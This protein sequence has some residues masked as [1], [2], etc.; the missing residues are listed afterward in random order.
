VASAR[1]LEIG[2]RDLFQPV[3]PDATLLLWTGRYPLADE[4]GRWNLRARRLP[5]VVKDLCAG[6]FDLVLC[7]ASRYAPWAPYRLL[8]SLAES[9]VVGFPNAVLCDL[10]QYLPL[11]AGDTPLAIVD[12]DD[13]PSIG[14]HMLP[15]MRRC[16]LYFKR[17]LPA[18]HWRVFFRTLHRDLPSPRMRRR[19]A[20][21]DCIG[22]LRPLSLGLGRA[23]IAAIGAPPAAKEVD[24]FFAG[25]VEGSSTV[26]QR[27]LAQLEALAAEGYR[28]DVASA[29]LPFE[30]F[31]RRC[32]RA[33][34]AWVPEG[35][36][37]DTYR[38][39]EAALCGA[40]PVMNY[41]TIERHR[42]L[43]DG[44]HCWLYDVSGDG[45][46]AT[47]RRA[48]SDPSRL[49]VMAAAARDHVLAHHTEA[50]LCSHVVAAALDQP[51][52]VRP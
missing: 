14:R 31:V 44:E 38:Q 30:E 27:G 28:L 50:A 25:L 37:W 47:V 24:L 33:R 1:I 42:P 45:L 22:K 20:L 49:T 11:L 10:G 13:T 26:R 51:A 40:V 35:L 21:R 43:V 8:R 9:R 46:V 39:Y 41:P 4:A 29:R 52:T 17:E 23:R 32:A 2:N 7:H 48:L 12:L 19:A 5:S 16:R 3:F 18:D 15:L 6:R 36:G 34:L